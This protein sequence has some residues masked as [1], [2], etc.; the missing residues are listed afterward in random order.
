MCLDVSVSRP[1]R[2]VMRL[3]Q[4]AATGLLAFSAVALV[5]CQNKD[6][7]NKTGSQSSGSTPAQSTSNVFDTGKL[8]A[9]VIGD[10]LPMVKKNGDA[11]DGLSFGSISLNVFSSRGSEAA[12]KRASTALI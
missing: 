8:R 4:R 3:I 7:D 1:D 5:A 11:Y 6:G 9:V 2:L 10:A 12:N